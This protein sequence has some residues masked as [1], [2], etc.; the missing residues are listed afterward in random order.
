MMDDCRPA[1]RNCVDGGTVGGKPCCYK[2]SSKHSLMTTPTTTTTTTRQA[3]VDDEMGR[4]CSVPLRAHTTYIKSRVFILRA[5]NPSLKRQQ[6]AGKL[7]GKMTI[8]NYSIIGP[9]IV[10]HL[11]IH[12]PSGKSREYVDRLETGD[13]TFRRFVGHQLT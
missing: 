7:C 10:G 3:A 11:N 13:Y 8:A 2:C 12:C 1:S 6:G 9:L 4:S 5:K